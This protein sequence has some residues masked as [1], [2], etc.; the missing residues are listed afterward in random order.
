[1]ILFEGAYFGEMQ[2]FKTVEFLFE[3]QSRFVTDFFLIV[4]SEK[5]TKVGIVKEA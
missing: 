4:N 2:G 5:I 3:V 1:M